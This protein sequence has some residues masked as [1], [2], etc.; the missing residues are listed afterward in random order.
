VSAAQ[1]EEEEGG[2]RSPESRASMSGGG[3]LTSPSA[4]VCSRSW[5]LL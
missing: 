1:A 4:P 2:F 3:S 5:Y